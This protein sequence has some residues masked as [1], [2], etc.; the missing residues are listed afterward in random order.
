MINVANLY[1]EYFQAIA[2]GRK[3][4]EIRKRLRRDPRLESINIGERVALLECGSDRIIWAQIVRIEKALHHGLYCY[5]IHLSNISITSMPGI[6]K[7]RGWHR[8]ESLQL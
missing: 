4:I 1:P 6:K 2:E 7:I 5:Y 8:R 3:R